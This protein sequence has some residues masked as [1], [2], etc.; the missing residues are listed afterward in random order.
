MECMPVIAKQNIKEK[1]IFIAMEFVI[2]DMSN[3]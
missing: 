1:E 3:N 2:E